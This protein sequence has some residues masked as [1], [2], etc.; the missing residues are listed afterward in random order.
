MASHARRRAPAVGVAC[1][2]LHPERCSSICRTVRVHEQHCSLPLAVCGG[3]NAR[4]DVRE[5]CGAGGAPL[6]A[7][8]LQRHAAAATIDCAGLAAVADYM[9]PCCAPSMAARRDWG[10]AAVAGSLDGCAQFAAVPC[11]YFV[12]THP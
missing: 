12:N 2:S 7:S 4:E 5:A 11:M 8:V 3:S 9:D 1:C 6:L 10:R